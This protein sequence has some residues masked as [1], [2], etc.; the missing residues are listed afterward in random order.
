MVT[1]ENWG[2]YLFDCEWPFLENPSLHAHEIYIQA[3]IQSPPCTAHTLQLT[4]VLVLF[5]FLLKNNP[6]LRVFTG[7]NMLLYINDLS[8]TVRSSFMFMFFFFFFFFFFFLSWLIKSTNSIHPSISRRVVV[9]DFMLMTLQQNNPN[10][11]AITGFYDVKS[12]HHLNIY[13]YDRPDY[14]RTFIIINFYLTAVTISISTPKSK[15]TNP[16]TTTTLN[17]KPVDRG[18]QVTSIN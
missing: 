6:L 4:S 9:G 2:S 15:L 10:L 12:I 16:Q 18:M 7:F 8:I 5:C 11:E 17:F 13:N 1:V 14:A 3:H